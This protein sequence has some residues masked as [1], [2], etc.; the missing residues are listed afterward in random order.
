MTTHTGHDGCGH[1]HQL[2]RQGL[3][4]E[5]QAC[6]K[7]EWDGHLSG[8]RVGPSQGDTWARGTLGPLTACP[9]DPSALREGSQG[10]GLWRAIHTSWQDRL[11]PLAGERFGPPERSYGA[12]SPRP[13]ALSNLDGGR[14]LFK[15]M[16]SEPW[17]CP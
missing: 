14:A 12:P 5:E 9:W 6:S 7:G 3:G 4:S 2:G 17:P 15:A 10:L 13:C 1:R 11:V 8:G 16:R